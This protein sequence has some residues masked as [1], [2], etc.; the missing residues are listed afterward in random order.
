MP[1]TAARKSKV[2]SEPEA[3]DGKP[4]AVVGLPGIKE[5]VRWAA[6]PT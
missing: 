2:K 4:E 6:L 5:A 3:V 1:S